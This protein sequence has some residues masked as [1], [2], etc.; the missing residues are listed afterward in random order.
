VTFGDLLTLL[1]TFF[2]LLISMSSMDS[3]HLKRTFGFFRGA[4]AALETSNGMADT[5]KSVTEQRPPL[6]ETLG[7]DPSVLE[8][9]AALSLQ[10]KRII[11]KARAITRELRDAYAAN[12][13][14]MHA[15][16]EHTL[17]LLYRS[18]PVIVHRTGRRMEM[19]IHVGLL[20]DR[21]TAQLRP[22]SE[23]LLV[24]LARLVRAG[25]KLRRIQTPIHEQGSIPRC[26][27][28]WDLAVWRSAAL[29]R[30]L[31]QR[32]AIASV[33]PGKDATHVKLVLVN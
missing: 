17:D 3:Q 25:A 23:P 1:I 2:V 10:I 27:S 33:L 22:E 24:E 14:G 19:A 32:E 20:F 21:S 30:R 18:R 16:D 7:A 8:Q 11:H 5:R 6:R 31:K 13:V 9:S 29:I 15:L 4:F 12:G 26:F 28:P